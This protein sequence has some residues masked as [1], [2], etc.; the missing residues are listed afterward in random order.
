EMSV[1]Y[2]AKAGFS[3]YEI[4]NFSRLGYNCKHNLNYW[5]NYPYVG[6]GPSAV[7]Y[8]KGV[9]E[10]NISNIQT[11]IG[12]VNAGKPPVVFREKLSLLKR[13]KE[14]AAIKIRTAEGINFRWFED[15]TGLD[16][17]ALE[18]DALVQPLKDKLIEHVKTKG[19]PAGIRLTKKGFLF[20]DTVS[21]ALL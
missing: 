14:T 21:A 8:V 19:K 12:R 4:S 2:L 6:F 13:A 17:E 1:V 20:C 11:Y 5:R 16:F 9:R 15:K 18:K 3:R 10:R 7:S